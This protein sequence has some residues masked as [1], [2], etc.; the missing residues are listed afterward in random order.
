MSRIK[1]LVILR[2]Y[3]QIDVEYVIVICVAMAGVR[4]RYKLFYFSY[5]AILGTR[6]NC[7]WL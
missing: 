1:N 5:I 7:H 6:A 3:D 4:G 2:I